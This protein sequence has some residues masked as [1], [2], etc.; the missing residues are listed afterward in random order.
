M[1]LAEVIIDASAV[2]AILL[3]E[4]DR[5]RFENAI[6]SHWPRRLSVASYLEVAMRLLRGA[7]PVTLTLLD[8]LIAAAEIQLEPVTVAHARLA[9]AAFARY[10]KGL[11]H[12]AQLNFGDCLTY[13]LAKAT[14]EP[15]LYKGHDFTHTDL[16]FV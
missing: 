8:R 5:Y 15:L 2:L 12:P 7:D 4:P 14:N 13:A 6:A 16:N 11:G 1:G 3:S 9:R 10:G